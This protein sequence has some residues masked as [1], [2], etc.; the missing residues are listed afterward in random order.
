MYEVS[1]SFGDCKDNGMSCETFQSRFHFT[2]ALWV[3]DFSELYLALARPF[4]NEAESE[5]LT[6]A[7][8]VI[9]FLYFFLSAVKAESTLQN[10]VYG[11]IAGIDV[12]FPGWPASETDICKLN[13][14][15]PTK[16]G[17]SYTEKVALPVAPSDPA[18]SRAVNVWCSRC[19]P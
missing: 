7:H 11:E 12:P 5:E 8:C 13:I 15:C 4:K 16:A 9:L 2:G 10:K 17:Q 19:M 18:V 3:Q 1:K 14:K 6:F